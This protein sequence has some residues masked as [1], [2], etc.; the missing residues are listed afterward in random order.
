MFFAA[1]KITKNK[2]YQGF[3]M[4]TGCSKYL[5]RFLEI[6]RSLKIAD[7]CCITLQS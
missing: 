6:E 3:K 4:E 1:K 2:N 5:P 7:V